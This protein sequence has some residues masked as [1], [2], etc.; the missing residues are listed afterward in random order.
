MEGK[1]RMAKRS[2][3]KYRKRVSRLKKLLKHN[4]ND[5]ID[6]SSMTRIIEVIKKKYKMAKT[7]RE[8]MNIRNI[9]AAGAFNKYG[10][11]ILACKLFGFSSNSFRNK[12]R[13]IRNIEKSKRQRLSVLKFLERDDNSIM[14]PGN[15][16]ST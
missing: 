9:F 7:Q 8:K 16:H 2:N 15:G 14:K 1:F 3:A 5:D 4:K 13:R 11:K 10:I 6:S 12:E